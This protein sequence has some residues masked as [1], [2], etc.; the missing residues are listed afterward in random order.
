MCRA[1]SRRTST[2]EATSSLWMLRSAMGSTEGKYEFDP[3]DWSICARC[4]A[5]KVDRNDSAL[6]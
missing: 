5:V 6:A 1:R 3:S 2:V 4:G